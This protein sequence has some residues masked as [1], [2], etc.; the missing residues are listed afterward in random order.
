ML[1]CIDMIVPDGTGT[2]STFVRT[3]W[4]TRRGADTSLSGNGTDNSPT[5]T[6]LEM[7]VE[8]SSMLMSAAVA[9]S[10]LMGTLL[11]ETVLLIPVILISPYEP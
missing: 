8:V 5:V 6:P 9:A 2:L 11:L 7:I 1:L 3:N 10:W 4:N